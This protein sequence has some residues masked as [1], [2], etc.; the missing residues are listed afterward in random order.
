MPR[1]KI[2]KN[3]KRNREA[4]NREEKIRIYELKM[5][6]VLMSIDD[7]EQRYNAM[8]ETQLQGVT[9]RLQSE[10][11]EMKMCD[12]LEI[13]PNLEHFGDFKA[14]D[15]TQHLGSQ[16][17]YSN[18]TN[19]GDVAGGSSTNC[20]AVTAAASSRN[21]EGYLTEDSSLGGAVS[22]SSA[23]T[24]S[25]YTGSM[26]RSAKAM[27]TPGPLHSARARRERRSRS[28]CGSV[29]PKV[30]GNTSTAIA[31]GSSNSIIIPN[32]HRNSR[33]KMRTPMATRPKAISADRTPRMLKKR[34]TSPS[35]PP[36][37]FLR[38]PKPGEVA[39]SKYGSPIVAQ[40]MPDKFANVNIPIRNGVLSLR[41]KKL[42]EVK[43][44]LLENLDEDTLN[45]IRTLHESLQ[46]IVNT[47]NKAAL[48]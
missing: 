9:L 30:L 38:W 16:S 47:A 26:L 29:I 48:K 21:D 5:D 24:L 8:V 25:A 43:A 42:A 12:F 37:A 15:Q 33:S 46:L 36:M 44:E 22:C 4:A 40:V 2:T 11:R 1:T 17:M 7:L 13:L 27:R 23:S 32:G 6:S 10:L 28:A 19:G 31:A 20:A 14:S 45:Q 3:S 34:N 18:T 35:T 41:P 39:L